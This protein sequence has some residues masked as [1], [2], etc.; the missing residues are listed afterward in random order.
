MTIWIP[1]LDRS[2]P[3]Y[4]AIADSIGQAIA[5]GAL[6]K[7]QRLPPQRDLAWKLGVTLGTVTRAY[8]QAELR[9]LLSGEV[10]RGSFIR[11]DSNAVVTAMAERGDEVIDLSQA[12]PPPMAGTAEFDAA[13]NH[14]MHDPNRLALLDYTAS[15]GLPAHRAMMVKWLQRS[16]I[17]AQEKDVFVTPGA[18]SALATTLDAL[19]DVQGGIV[20]ED[21]NYAHLNQLF[22]RA[23]LEVLAQPMDENGLLPDALEAAVA[24]SKARL[25]YLVPTLQ[26]P[27]THTMSR[28]R[29]EDIVTVARK[30]DVTIIED[31][32]FRLLDERVQPPT[33]YSLAPER[34]Y[35]ISSLSKTLAPGLR[36]GFVLTPQGQDRTMRSHVR[37]MAPRTSA[38]TGEVARYWIEGDMASTI[39]GRTR[40]EL[41]RR[42]QGFLE[43][44]KD[45]KF[46]CSPGAP[47]AWLEVPEPWT[48]SRFAAAALAQNIKISPGSIFELGAKGKARH[49]VRVCFGSPS[50]FGQCLR[51]FQDLHNLLSNPPED[52]FTPVA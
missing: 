1:E 15:E 42:R 22:Q 40:A 16:G 49:N 41:G 28:Q 36:F 30:Y 4:L 24:K 32:I 3:L 12:S 29:R 10:G 8:K 9:G 6:S 31:D 45:C 13:L 43:I 47:Y 20:A 17:E 35:H 51:A 21:I 38:M 19:Q 50:S 27:T 34:T 25:L 39:L 18:H 14:L 52:E 5:S 46:F 48:G 26:N 23:K 7:G 44:F 2:K 33:F 11:T 37:S